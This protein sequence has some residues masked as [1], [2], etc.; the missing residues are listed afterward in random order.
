MS[1]NVKVCRLQVI[2]NVIEQENKE[3][4]DVSSE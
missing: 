3:F 1:F 2:S 4:A